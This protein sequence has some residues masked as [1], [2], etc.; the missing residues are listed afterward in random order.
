MD[1]GGAQLNTGIDTTID[2]AQCKAYLR[3]SV[4]I[5]LRYSV[6]ISLSYSVLK[7]FFVLPFL[8]TAFSQN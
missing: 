7:L 3:Y 4:L 6:L 2:P 1:G 8:D 5:Y